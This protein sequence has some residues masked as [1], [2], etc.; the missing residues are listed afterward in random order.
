MNRDRYVLPGGSHE[1]VAQARGWGESDGVQD[2]VD[3]AE[4]L[5]GRSTHT[6]DMVGVGCVELGNGSFFAVRSVMESP[7]PAPVSITVAPCSCASLATPNANDAS[8]STPVIT[9]RLPARIA[10]SLR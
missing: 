4:M 1:I 9:S 10:T 2:A 7:R 5:L 3:P 6:R 8:V